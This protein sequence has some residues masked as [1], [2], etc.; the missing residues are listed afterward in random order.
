MKWPKLYIIL[1]RD[2]KALENDFYNMTDANKCLSL[3]PPM[4]FV[5]IAPVHIP[6]WVIFLF[7]QLRCPSVSPEHNSLKRTL[8]PKGQVYCQSHMTGSHM[9]EVI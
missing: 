4:K 3:V 8:T 7:V 1:E 2:N 9:R 6:G 5:I